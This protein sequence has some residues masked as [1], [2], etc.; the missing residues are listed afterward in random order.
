MIFERA[1]QANQSVQSM[2]ASPTFE[3]QRISYIKAI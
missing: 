1:W 2:F 3:K